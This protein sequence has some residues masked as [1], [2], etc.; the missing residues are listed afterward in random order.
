[1]VTAAVVVVMVAVAVVV[2]VSSCNEV[3]T[4]VVVVGVMEVSSSIQHICVIMW[5]IHPIHSVITVKTF[6]HL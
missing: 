5:F 2:V 4:A 6:N 3:A 1:M